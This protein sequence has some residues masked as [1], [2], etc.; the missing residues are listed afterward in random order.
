[1]DDDQKSASSDSADLCWLVQNNAT[2]CN[3]KV[4]SF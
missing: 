4:L 2:A 3:D 1:M